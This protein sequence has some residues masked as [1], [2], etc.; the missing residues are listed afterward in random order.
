MKLSKTITTSIVIV[1]IIILSIVIGFITQSIITNAE[2]NQY[3]KEFSELVEEYS[4][5]YGVPEYVVYSIIKVESDFDSGLVGEGGAVGLMQ[6]KRDTFMKLTTS[7]TENLD[8]AM[9]YDP[10][11]NIDYGAYYLSVLYVRYGSWKEV[12]SA[13]FKGTDVVDE[14]LKDEKLCDKNGKLAIIPDRDTE[15]Y[16]K[17]LLKTNE[18]YKSLY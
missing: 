14:W 11:T 15:E 1:V 4:Y 2:R 17:L 6:I 18:K 5:E 3:P 9:L 10:E 7:R 12:Y 13:Y 8:P 16:A